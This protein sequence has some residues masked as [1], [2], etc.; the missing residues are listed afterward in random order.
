MSLFKKKAK[1]AI[2]LPE[3]FRGDFVYSP[4]DW[5]LRVKLNTKIIIP[6]GW[7]GIFVAK[8]RPCDVLG[9]GEYV[10]DTERLP[11]ISKLLKLNKPL[12]KERHGK[13]EK[14]Y[15]QEFDAFVYFVNQKPLSGLEWETSEIFLKKK[16]VAPDEKKR[17]DV[18]LGGNVDVTCTEPSEMMRFFLYEWARVD[19]E[20]AK[21]RITEFVEEIV[22]ETLSRIKTI[23]VQ[24]VDDSEGLAELILPS[25]QKEFAEY[26]MNIE[27]FVINKTIFDKITASNLRQEKLENNIA[28]DEI[29]E[30]GAEI[31]VVDIKVTKESKRGRKSAVAE[32]DEGEVLDMTQDDDKTA[33]KKIAECG[34][35]DGIEE[36]ASDE[37]TKQ[38][39]S[40]SDNIE[41]N[42][43]D[44]TDTELP[45]V[46]LS[47]QK[48]DK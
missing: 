17:Y 24:E 46:V 22:Q 7:W 42:D 26:G 40:E 39:S 30:L 21:S 37:S 5:M 45:K 12:K 35:S 48:I 19:N 2:V 4:H 32:A 44:I 34:Q 33:P 16:T 9:A 3:K 23:S 43:S 14:V 20:R 1:D 38:E 28:S 27:N 41:N 47:D 15:R 31:S 6:Q 13:T 25:L 10:L 8:D 36:R 18:V 29:N 11:K